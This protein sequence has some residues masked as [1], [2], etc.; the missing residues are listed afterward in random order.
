MPGWGVPPSP[1]SQRMGEVV[2]SFVVGVVV[3]M[4]L[5]ALRR[6]GRERRTFGA[7]GDAIARPVDGPRFARYPAVR[8]AR[9]R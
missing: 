5:L 2:A 3:V 4:V 9:R 1:L 6:R 7:L 8:R